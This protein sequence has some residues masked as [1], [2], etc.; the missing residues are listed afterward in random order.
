[1]T[2]KSSDEYSDHDQY[3][4]GENKMISDSRIAKCTRTLF[5]LLVATTTVSQAQDTGEPPPNMPFRYGLGHTQFQD[6]CSECHGQSM[7]G[8]EKGPPL[9][10]VYYVPSH[11]G[12]AAI[13]RAIQRGTKQHHWK[14]G[15]MKP[16][17]GIAENEARAIVEY[18]RWY[19]REK[20]LY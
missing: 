7:E 1:M 10:H 11:H 9:M 6:H 13:I 19:Q 5:W 3:Q 15:D 14:F 8:A 2:L 20:G 4:N 12:D 16:V 17:A 18:I